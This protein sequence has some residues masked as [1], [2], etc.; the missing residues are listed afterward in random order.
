MR[1]QEACQIIHHILWLYQLQILGSSSVM[2]VQI[3]VRNTFTT[4]GANLQKELGNTHLK[5]M[6]SSTIQKNRMIMSSV[7]MKLS[8][9]LVGSVSTL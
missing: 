5:R 1:S 6:A 4:T 3:R 7:I 8:L 2:T 9:L